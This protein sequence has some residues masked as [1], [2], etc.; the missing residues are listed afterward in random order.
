MIQTRSNL[1][2]GLIDKFTP[3]LAFVCKGVL[4][5]CVATVFIAKAICTPQFWTRCKTFGGLSPRHE[6][7]PQGELQI[8]EQM[9]LEIAKRILLSRAESR[10]QSLNG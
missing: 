2:G 3:I 9:A 5:F 10:V 7:W 4:G 6:P 8:A 1:T